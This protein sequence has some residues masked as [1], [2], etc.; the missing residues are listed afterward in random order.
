MVRWLKPEGQFLAIHYLIPDSDGPPFGTTPSEVRARFSTDFD[1][2]SDWVPRSYPNRTGL[3]WMAWWKTASLA[4][5]PGE[6]A[7]AQGFR[8]VRGPVVSGKR[9]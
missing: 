5:N 1:L 9:S 7:R 2:V 8:S 3:E 4:G 6:R